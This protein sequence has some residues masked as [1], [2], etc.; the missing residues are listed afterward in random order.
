MSKILRV[1]SVK[2]IISIQRKIKVTQNWVWKTESER[3]LRQ[4][5]R[6]LVDGREI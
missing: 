6:Q 5:F 4:K 3:V 1:V 2:G